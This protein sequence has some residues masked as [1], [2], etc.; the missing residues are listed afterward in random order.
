[1][2]QIWGDDL[3]TGDTVIDRYLSEGYLA[4]RGMS[5]RF[6]GAICAWLMLHQSAQRM[7]GH[8][9]EIGTF[10]G[11]LFVAL[12]LALRDNEQGLGIDSFDWPSEKVYDHFLENCRTHGVDIARVTAWKSNTGAM[13]QQSLRAQLGPGSVRFFHIDGDHSPAALA[14]DLALATSVLHPQGLMCLDDMLHP[15][16]PF[17]VS[18]VQ[19]YLL[20]EKDMRL[21]AVIDREDIVGAAKFL[22]CRADAVPLY[23]N[24][25]MARYPKR[26]FVLGGDALGHHCVV[27]TPEPRLAVVD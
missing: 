3:L 27:L 1:M 24:A 11:R 22:I 16:Y 2:S 10:E 14:H 25:L 21:M 6:A 20:R 9:A 13:T 12:A 7:H 19:D 15:A 8:L 26:H 4:V 5:S 18:T 23:E 17:L